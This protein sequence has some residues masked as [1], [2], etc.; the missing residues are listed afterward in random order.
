M[1]TVST[2]TNGIEVS[3]TPNYHDDMSK[4]SLNKFIHSYQVKITNLSGIEV[5]LLRRHW[6]ITD[7][8]SKVR[9]VKGDGVIG[10]QPIIEPNQYHRYKSWCP[11]STPVGKMSGSFTMMRVVDRSLFEVEVPEFRL[12]ADFK[13]N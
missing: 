8:N 12:I 6:I 11:L 7:A 3:V 9:D 5:Q 2:T 13:N 10:L 4:P 1:N